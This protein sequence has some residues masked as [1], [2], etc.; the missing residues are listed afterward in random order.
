MNDHSKLGLLPP[1]PEAIE[2]LIAVV[3][4]DHALTSPEDQQAYLREWRGRYIGRTPLVLR[5]GTTEEVAAIMAIANTERIAIVVQGGNTGLVGGQIPSETGTEVILS[6]GRLRRIRDLNADAGHITVEAGVTLAE[7]QAAAAAADRLFPLS[8]ASE[9]TCTIGGNLATNAGGVGVLAYGS[10]R[11]LVLGLEVVLADGRVWNGLR[12][13]KKDNTGYDLKQLF[14]G[15][16]GTLGIITAAVLKL[17]PAAATKATAFVALPHLEAALKFFR[18]AERAAGTSLTAFEFISRPA[19]D[20]VL[21][22][23][24]GAR[25]PFAD[26][27]HPWHVL[28]EISATSPTVEPDELMQS[29]LAEALESGLIADAAIAGSIGQ[30]HELWRLRESISE[31]QLHEG[32]SIK[33]D[34]SVPIARIPE[35]VERAASV[36][37]AICPGSRPIVFGHFGDGNIHYNVSQPLQMNKQAYLALWEPMNEAVHALVTEF[38]GSISAEHGIGRMKRDALARLRDPVELDLM[39]QLKRTLDPR[40]ILNP[41]KLL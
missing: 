35:F 3:G 2:R 25:A 16:E 22:H 34:I 9:G 13:L 11:Q 7:V 14:I 37:E 4:P 29:L 24:E 20:V 17:M 10:A 5:P 38:G 19:L 31:A 15:S 1:S 41:G 30:A 36:V 18:A 23:I 39:R 12:A 33:H 40:G 28:L 8:L 21:R 32:G 27:L 26:H 6:T